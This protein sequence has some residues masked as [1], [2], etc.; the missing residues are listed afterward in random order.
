[1]FTTV[2]NYIMPERECSSKVN[3]VNKPN[4]P[5]IKVGKNN[6]FIKGVK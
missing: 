2:T 6:D 5:K 3:Q 1:M 4:L